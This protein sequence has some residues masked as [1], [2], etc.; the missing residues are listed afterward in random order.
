MVLQ[1][2]DEESLEMYRE[3]V[4]LY[5]ALAEREGMVLVGP[6]GALLFKPSRYRGLKS[7]D[8]ALARARETAHYGDDAETVALIVRKHW[9]DEA[10]TVLERALEHAREES[11]T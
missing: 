7:L 3:N 8:R 10:V 6:D 2:L 4:S 5:E 11:R 9:G 1:R